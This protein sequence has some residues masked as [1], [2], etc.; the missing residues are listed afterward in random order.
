M[1]YRQWFVVSLLILINVIVFG[2]LILMLTG[3][4][5]V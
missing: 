2:C 5:I 1:T 4:M 3:K